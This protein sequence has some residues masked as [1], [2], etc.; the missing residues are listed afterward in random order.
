MTAWQAKATKPQQR[1]MDKAWPASNVYAQIGRRPINQVPHA[2][3]MYNAMIST[4]EQG[5]TSE[6]GRQ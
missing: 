5:S 3:A 1:K 6:E 4:S 2:D